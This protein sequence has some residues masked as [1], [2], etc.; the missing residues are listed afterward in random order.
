M[1]PLPFEGTVHDSECFVTVKVAELQI[2]PP[3]LR[4]EKDATCPLGPKNE[5]MVSP[6]FFLG[7]KPRGSPSVS[8]SGTETNTWLCGEV[9]LP[10]VVH[11]LGLDQMCSLCWGG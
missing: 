10:G 5:Q 4:P 3:P 2:D 11:L 7:D 6:W 9:K 1:L 8:L